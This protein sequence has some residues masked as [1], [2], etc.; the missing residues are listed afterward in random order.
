MSA[1]TFD[2]RIW[3]ALAIIMA[4]VV[5][6]VRLALWQRSAPEPDHAPPWRLATLIGLQVLAG[7]LLWLTL[8][9]P[10]GILRAGTLIVATA[11][12]PASIQQS[13]GDVLIALPEAGEIAGA[14]L[15]DNALRVYPQ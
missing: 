8:F 5:G 14:I 12:S 7:A 10:A 4:V 13:T 15:R 11:G 1:G 3:V 2:A 6:I 9:P